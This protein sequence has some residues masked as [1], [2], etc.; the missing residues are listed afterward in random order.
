MIPLN[1]PI[2]IKM[3]P[4][5]IE[6]NEKSQISSPLFTPATLLYIQAGLAI[7]L[8]RLVLYTYTAFEAQDREPSS[9]FLAKFLLS[10]AFLLCLCLQS[11]S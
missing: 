9:W 3:T 11:L 1:H 5:A 10:V 6:M 8:A 7:V 4:K 2:H